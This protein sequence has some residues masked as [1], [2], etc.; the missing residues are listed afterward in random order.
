MVYTP[1][2]GGADMPTQEIQA[3]KEALHGCVLFIAHVC[4]HEHEYV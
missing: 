2:F 1:G 4:V 3:R